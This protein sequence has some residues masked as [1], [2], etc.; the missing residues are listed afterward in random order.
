MKIEHSDFVYSFYCLLMFSPNEL[1]DSFVFEKNVYGPKVHCSVKNE[2][3]SFG[4]IRIL[5]IQLII[6]SKFYNNLHFKGEK[7]K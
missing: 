7:N 6:M 5:F 2:K 1:G 3:F 4:L